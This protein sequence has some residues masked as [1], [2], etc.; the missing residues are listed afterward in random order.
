MSEVGD[1][2][3]SVDVVFAFIEVSMSSKEVFDALNRRADLIY[4]ATM[5][6]WMIKMILRIP[7]SSTV[8]VFLVMSKA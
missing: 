1:G 4:S 6:A 3:W 5:V 7:L 2:L 8:R